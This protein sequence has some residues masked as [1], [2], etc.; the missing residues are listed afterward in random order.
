VIIGGIAA[1]KILVVDDNQE[2]TAILEIILE[3]AG[4]E[5]RSANDGCDG[6]RTYMRFKPD[7]V[8]TDLHMPGKSGIELMKVIRN[9]N[10]QV[11]TIYMSGELSRFRS[12]LEEE[13]KKYRVS[14]LQKPFS[15]LELIKLISKSPD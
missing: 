9:E 3:G 12:S 7:L 10:P 5:V 6:F 2:L 15:K 4:Y 11:R 13:R 1:T 8:L 14:V